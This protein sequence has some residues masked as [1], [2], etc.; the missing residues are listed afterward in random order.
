MHAMMDKGITL[1][2]YECLEH[3]DGQRII[4]F[5]FFAGVVGAHNGMMAYGNRTQALLT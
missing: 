4:G 5:G 2:D 1:I 3:E